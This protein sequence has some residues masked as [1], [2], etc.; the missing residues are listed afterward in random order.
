MT[1]RSPLKNPSNRTRRLARVMRALLCIVAPAAIIAACSDEP[2]APSYEYASIENQVLTGINAHRASLSLGALQ[3]N[4][5]IVEQARQHSQTMAET[6]NL[7]HDGFTDRA[8]AI[9]ARIAVVRVGENVA[10]NGGYA[11]PVAVAIQGW[12]GSPPHK[13]NIEGDYNLTGIGVAR[14]KDGA[15]YF[16]QI[17]AKSQ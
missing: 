3:S 1:R 6:D 2:T 17:F 11:D 5:V 16:T 9:G 15:Y 7:S 14:A 12:L 10:M 4:D 8:A 13:A